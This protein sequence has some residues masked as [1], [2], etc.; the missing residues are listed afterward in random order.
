MSFRDVTKQQR[1]QEVIRSS[2]RR[3][4]LL[5]ERNVA[6][7]FRASLDGRILEVND[8]FARMVGHDTPQDL[9]GKSITELYASLPERRRF[10]S[11]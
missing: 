5:F 1:A 8:A 10:P 4:R 3:Y 6:G 2:E 7:V 9:E 11:R